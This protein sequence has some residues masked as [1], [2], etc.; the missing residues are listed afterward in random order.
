MSTDSHLVPRDFLSRFSSQNDIQHDVLDK[1]PWESM[2]IHENKWHK[3][4]SRHKIKSGKERNARM[5]RW[6]CGWQKSQGFPLC[7]LSSNEG[8][9][10]RDL[11]TTSLALGLTTDRMEGANN[12]VIR[13]CNQA[14]HLN[15]FHRIRCRLQFIILP[16]S[17]YFTFY[18]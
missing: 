2:R 6:L 12:N 4:L 5:N 3:S 10:S 11:T 7:V 9:T 18:C 1:N 15:N 16:W 13:E 8:N 17:S 14:R